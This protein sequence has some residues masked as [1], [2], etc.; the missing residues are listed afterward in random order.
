MSINL[1]ES[2]AF[3]VSA[4][5]ISKLQK[6]GYKEL[7][8]AQVAAL[9]AGLCQGKSLLVCAPTSSGKTTIAEI[10]AVEGA[11]KGFRTVYL[12]SHKALAEEKFRLFSAEYGTGKGKWFDVSIAI[13][14]HTEG[15]WQQGL[16][17]ATYEKYLALLC[18]TQDFNL[19]STVIVADELQILGEDGRGPEIE[20]LCSLIRRGKPVQFVAL[21]ATIS[22]PDEIADWLNCTPIHL[23]KRDVPL[24][25]EVWYQGALTHTNAGESEVYSFAQE[26]DRPTNTISAI[27]YLLAK[28]LGP[29]LVF[30]TT[31]PRAITLAKSYSEKKQKLAKALIYVEQLELFSE[32]SLLTS[33]LKET[34]QRGVAFHT[35][36]LTYS[37]R[38]LVESGLTDRQFDV[39]F[40]TPTLAAGVNFPFQTVLFDSIYRSFIQ[41]TPWL[42][43]STYK[44]MSGRAGR[45]G[46]HDRG[47]SVVI[48]QDQVNYQYA[49]KLITSQDTPLRSVFAS[50]SLRKIVLSVIASR[51][52]R[53]HTE[54]TAFFKETLWWHLTSDKNPVSLDQLPERLE[55]STKWLA[56]NSLITL[57]GDEVSPTRLGVAVGSSG[58]LPQSA[59]SL[60]TLLKINLAGLDLT[61][62]EKWQ[63]SIIHALCASE[64]FHQEGGQR[65]LPFAKQTDLAANMYIQNNTFFIDPNSVEKSDAVT[66]AT[67]ALYRWMEGEYERQLST[68]VPSISYGY[69][70]QL[71]R[72]V[73]WILNGLVT[74]SRVP[75]SGIPVAL[76][77]A[78]G[79]IAERLKYGVP[80]EI[81]DVVKASIAYDVPGFGRNRAMILYKANL[82]S[83]NDILVA[84]RDQLV[85]LLEDE[86]RADQ[87]IIA[88]THYFDSSLDAW[89]NRHIE[90]AMKMQLDPV[91]IQRSYELTGDEYEN[92][93][94]ELLNY[95]TEWNVTKIDAHKRQGYPDFQIYFGDKSILF[96]CKT[97]QS[98]NATISKDDAFAILIKGAD[99]QKTHSLTLGKPDFDEFSKIK[100]NGSQNI[101]LICHKD[102]IEAILRYKAG[103]ISAESLFNWLLIPGFAQIDGLLMATLPNPI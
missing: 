32:P 81:I 71:G 59:I 89:K 20:L 49:I 31:R 43:E 38:S 100:S 35:A 90:R 21:S 17:I 76:A 67:F 9:Q 60:L 92:P 72:D 30:T 44:N 15:D 54:L 41:K 26:E 80:L 79:D 11:L 18:S 14:D 8:E 85:K 33:V 34:S 56:E 63:H 19:S 74:I 91:A 73:S 102:F 7:T 70:Q 6:R 13:G 42:P 4:G 53:R 40:A 103:R 5:L 16:L 3:G 86:R 12:V 10:A 69:I 24:R 93:I 29:I 46:M 51:A 58:L 52:I 75:E 39:V 48:P 83:P 36:D 68:L 66:N 37:E 2:S 1:T 96:E 88:L 94:E 27:D 45:L 47:Y 62:P 55:D 23:H 22:N 61:T 78:L 57:S 25:Q 84:P 50:C 65:F 101:T 64:E 28:G 87:L 97:K 95:V 98:N 99:F 82:A 77:N